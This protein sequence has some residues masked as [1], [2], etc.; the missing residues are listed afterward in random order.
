M[1]RNKSFFYTLNIPY[2]NSKSP[3]LLLW[4]RDNKYE[5]THTHIPYCT[6]RT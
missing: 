1:I 3:P 5:M 6:P 2:W 4:Q